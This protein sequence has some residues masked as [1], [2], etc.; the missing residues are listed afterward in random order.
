MTNAILIYKQG[1]FFPLGL[2]IFGVT[3]MLFGAGIFTSFYEKS[4]F[5]VTGITS[6]L[7]VIGSCF[8]AVKYLIIDKDGSVIKDQLHL[9]GMKFRSEIKLAEYCY[10]TLFKQMYS[11]TASNR[12]MPDS[13]I[14]FGKFDVL[15]LNKPHY[16]KLKIGS[17]DSYDEAMTAAKELSE[18]LDFDV[19]KFNPVRKRKV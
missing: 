3:L 1:Y 17:Y 15:L 18:Y 8:F 5:M 13:T 6:L 11:Q 2:R 14:H 19:V 4:P 10:I 7:V 9:L 16:K 12:F